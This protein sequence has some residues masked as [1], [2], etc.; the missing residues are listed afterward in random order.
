MIHLVSGDLLAYMCARVQHPNNVN[1]LERVL[2]VALLPVHRK[3]KV[4]LCN[5]F[6]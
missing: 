5:M 6:G 1:D 4:L 3:N 2:K